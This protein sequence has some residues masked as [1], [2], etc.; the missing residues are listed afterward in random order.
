MGDSLVVRYTLAQSLFLGVYYGT[1]R[2]S[3]KATG[4]SGLRSWGRHSLRDRWRGYEIDSSA[5]CI[6]C[7]VFHDDNYFVLSYPVASSVMPV[8]LY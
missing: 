8:N 4:A 2:E 1:S 6:Y 5:K 7:I 3:V